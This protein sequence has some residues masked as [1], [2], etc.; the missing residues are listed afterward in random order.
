MP[1]TYEVRRVEDPRTWDDF[2]RTALGGTIF[3]THAWLDCAS[4]ATNQSFHCYGAYKNGSLIAGVSGLE[5]RHTGFK[6]LTTPQ[7][8][9]YGGLLFAPVPSK[10]PAKLEAEWGR[11]T[12]LLIAYLL[13]H[14]DRVHLS[15]APPVQ[16]VRKF[17]WSNWHTQIHYTYEIDLSD[18]DVLWERVERWSLFALTRSFVW[19][20][21]A[22]LTPIRCHALTVRC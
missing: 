22:C 5:S 3:S 6:Y 1:H 19:M 20:N 12:E 10:G 9:P 13:E 2:A 21:V 7:L 11:A 14:Y 15:L 17:T 4:S 16:D 8:T 18:L